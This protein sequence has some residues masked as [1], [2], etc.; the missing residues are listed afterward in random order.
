MSDAYASGNNR[1]E[2]GCITCDM[3]SHGWRHCTETCINCK[4]AH[5]RQR[6]VVALDDY[7]PMGPAERRDALADMHAS[8]DDLEAQ[9]RELGIEEAKWAMIAGFVDKAEQDYAEEQKPGSTAAGAAAKAAA[10]KQDAEKK[11]AKRPILPPD[12]YTDAA[13]FLFKPLIGWK[14]IV[15]GWDKINTV[16][17]GEIKRELNA[18]AAGAVDMPHDSPLRMALM[19]RKMALPARMS[20]TGEATSKRKA[21]EPA[22]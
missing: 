15:P 4:M 21:A 9:V 8:N 12:P 22:S 20:E 11:D 10:E 19:A 2:N 6:C 7:P 5:H 13:R 17:K 18:Q 16:I 1:G 3:T 14:E